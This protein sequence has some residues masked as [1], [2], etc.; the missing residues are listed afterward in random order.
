MTDPPRGSACQSVCHA[1]AGIS[2]LLDD[3]SVHQ[4]AAVGTRR[5]NRALLTGQRGLRRCYLSRRQRSGAA[6]QPAWNLTRELLTGKTAGTTGA[7][8][9]KLAG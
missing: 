6:G 2:Q 1:A 4:R 3:R 8:A 7:L 9:G 5:R